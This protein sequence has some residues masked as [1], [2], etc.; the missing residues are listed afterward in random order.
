[1]IKLIIVKSPKEK[2]DVTNIV[3]SVEWSGDINAFAR[4][5]NVELKN[6]TNQNS[7]PLIK[8]DLGN[9]VVFY[10]QDKELFRG[11][12][13]KQSINH[14][15]DVL[16]TAYDNLIYT[17]KNTDSLIV[18]NKSASEVIS[19]LC[20]KFGIPIGKI[21]PTIFK[22]SKGVFQNKLIS[23]IFFE[24]LDET[25]KNVN[26]SY[27]LSS[28]R[29]KVNLVSRSKASKL[30]ISINDVI[31]ASSESSIEDMKTQ[32]M[33][34]KG[35]LDSKDKKF[36]THV[37]KNSNL[38]KKYGVMQAV[39]DMDDKATSS[40]MKRKAQSLLKELSKIESTIQIEFMGDSS[41]ITGNIIEIKNYMTGIF[42]RFY[43]SSDSH[44]FSDGIHKMSLQLSRNLE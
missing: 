32:V 27:R 20:R 16:F 30:T 37:E 21:E 7:T 18:K 29:G 11:F 26:R 40:Q 28:D 2:L 13:F 19:N 23:D 38:I 1:M 42:G 41:C 17:T 3:K 10:K 4:T 8:F 6:A 22:I 39:E 25:R 36:I 43:I 12:I 5:L 14:E 31:S 15:G 44:S 35:S 24:C 33:V 34:T 9:S